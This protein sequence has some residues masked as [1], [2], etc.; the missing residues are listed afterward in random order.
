MPNST[1]ELERLARLRESGALTEE[2]FALQKQRLL[3]GIPPVASHSQSRPGFTT[4]AKV[5]IAGLTLLTIIAI[6][7]VWFR[8]G[9][10][11]AAGNASVE[12]DNVS[13]TFAGSSPSEN[14][15][16]TDRDP[17]G[18]RFTRNRDPMT[19]RF[20]VTA[21][22]T[23][24]AS[25]YQVRTAIVCDGGNSL[26]Y[27]FAFTN[28]TGR[29]V[30]L[31]RHYDG[32]V[33]TNVAKYYL[34][35]D[36]TNYRTLYVLDPRFLNSFTLGP[37]A[38][39]LNLQQSVQYA[40]LSR[41]APPATSIE[42]GTAQ[43]VVIRAELASGDATVEI[44]QS[45]P[46]LRALLSRCS[47]RMQGQLEETMRVS[48]AECRD[49]VSCERYARLI[50]ALNSQGICYG[51]RGQRLED[52]EAHRCGPSSIRDIEAVTAPQSARRANEQSNSM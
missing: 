36:D 25:P 51:Q 40:L 33:E 46:E 11:H 17:A 42:L 35:L 28:E 43:R 52:F 29:P 9:A 26:S 27:R 4:F 45:D 5:A 49:G 10:N 48:A 7:Y 24:S 18:W 15:L 31:R 12:T 39:S 34:R 8:P 30:P 1:D 38:L 3:H 23:Y 44:D 21:E 20:V 50:V 22:R 37:P 16:A 13:A 14:N 2:E 6:I 47:Q 32:F 19:D 41:V